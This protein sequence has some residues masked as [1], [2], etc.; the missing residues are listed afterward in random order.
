MYRE[1][2]FR[3]LNNPERFSYFN[4]LE[5]TYMQTKTK[6][7]KDYKELIKAL[8]SISKAI[9]SEQYL[10]DIL[11]LIV[12]V[13]AEVTGFRICS[14]MLLDDKQQKLAIRATQSVSE[15]YNKKPHLKL[16]EGIAGKVAQDNKAMIV[17]DVI[18]EKEYKYKHIAEKENLKSLLCI[19]LSVKSKVI[20]VL[21][22][23]T[24][25]EHDF[26]ETE[27]NILTAIANQAAVAIENT[28]LM[29][30][31]RVIQEELEARKIIERAKG[32]LM[33]DEHLTEEQAYLKVRKYS[34]DNR[35][36]MREVSEAI[37]L[38]SGLKI[39]A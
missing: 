20:G 10:E 18:K 1:E 17:K 29:V 35:K 32:I 16:G 24:S 7:K 12:V 39:K 37:I 25:T 4:L 14:I 23:Y 13:I 27:I 3:D 9:C 38:A 15:E 5:K 2:A 19:P 11:K 8:S 31:S 33:R 21:N 34:M 6:S 28:E 30:K 36:T 26:S 22:C